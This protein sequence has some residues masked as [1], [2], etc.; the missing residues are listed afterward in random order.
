MEAILGKKYQIVIP[1]QVRKKIKPL[2]PGQK[3]QVYSTSENTVVLKIT[4][5]SWVAENF[6][7]FKQAWNE[8]P[9][10]EIRKLREEWDETS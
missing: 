4:D 8:D 9:V 6:G 10:A 3:I 1:K 7:R 5:K 2:S